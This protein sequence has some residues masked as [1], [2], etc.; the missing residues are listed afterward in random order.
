M[1]DIF[2]RQRAK[3]KITEAVQY[4]SKN[5][6]VKNEHFRFSDNEVDKLLDI[7]LPQNF[8]SV[9]SALRTALFRID[10]SWQKGQF[11]VFSR[12]FRMKL[13]QALYTRRLSLD[14][15]RTSALTVEGILAKILVASQNFDDYRKAAFYAT[16]L[17]E[18]I[19]RC[20]E[21]RLPSWIDFFNDG[22]NWRIVWK[23][24]SSLWLE[25]YY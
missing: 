5:K 15:S 14:D 25:F 11:E 20:P 19:L 22:P 1:S 16:V 17:S 7:L 24:H 4:A 9:T 6:T 18:Y 21:E 2:E 13:F 10:P 3:E 8:S 23:L 12:H